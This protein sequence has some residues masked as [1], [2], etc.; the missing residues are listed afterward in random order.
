MRRAARVDLNHGDIR[1]A[2]RALGCKVFDA[3]GVGKGF[4]DLCV[5]WGGLVMLCEVKTETGKLT[6][7][8][9]QLEL[10][11]RLVRNLKDVEETVKTL[12]RWSYTL[13]VHCMDDYSDTAIKDRG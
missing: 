1:T 3:S 8:Q 9:E 6:K 12:R 7:R 11:A 5:A 13:C 10:P 4:P 2:F